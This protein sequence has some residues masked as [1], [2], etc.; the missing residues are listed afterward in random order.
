[1][2][3]KEEIKDLVEIFLKDLERKDMLP[4]YGDSAQ[5][6][7]SKIIP[8]NNGTKLKTDF[9]ELRIYYQRRK[10]Q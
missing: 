7:I 8:S 3:T 4:K 2:I 1:M 5:F 9:R 6:V 10:V